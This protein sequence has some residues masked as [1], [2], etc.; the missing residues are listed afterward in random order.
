MSPSKYSKEELQCAIQSSISWRE[1][2][3]KLGV[4]RNEKNRVKAKERASGFGFNF[5]HFLG[6]AAWKGKKNNSNSKDPI[7]LLTL[8]G[9]KTKSHYLK[10]RL[11]RFGYKKH[12]CEKCNNIHWNGELIPIELHHINGNKND[13]RLEN[14][15][16]LCPNCHAQTPNYTAKNKK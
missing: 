11:I 6:Q 16:I 15:Q 3:L 14:L 13:N 10:G 7:Y 9:T 4:C 1:T 12:C 5:S 2:L 8:N